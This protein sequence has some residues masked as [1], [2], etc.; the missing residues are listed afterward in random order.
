MPEGIGYRFQIGANGNREDENGGQGRGISPQE[1]V[2]ILSLRVPERPSPTAVVPLELLNSPGGA[3]AGAQ[4]LDS[5]IA[6][7]IQAFRPPFVGGGA[8]GSAGGGA[9]A[10]PVL[11]PLPGLPPMTPGAPGPVAPLPIGDAPSAPGQ[12]P[13]IPPGL[14]GDRNP[15]QGTIGGGSGGGG[16]RGPIYPRTSVDN[17]LFVDPFSGGRHGGGTRRG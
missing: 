10:A 14:G 5:M 13:R 12:A 17:D 11:P 9:P 2:K 6:A 4:G 16:S 15:R 1:A 3:A 7:L 8:S